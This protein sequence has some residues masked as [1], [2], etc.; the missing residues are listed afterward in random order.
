MKLRPH[1][2]AVKLTYQEFETVERRV[3]GIGGAIRWLAMASDRR[4]IYEVSFAREMTVLA[5]KAWINRA[6]NHGKGTH[7]EGIK[8]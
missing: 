8:A 4:E 3:K 6:F 5:F 1:I 2:C 7:Y